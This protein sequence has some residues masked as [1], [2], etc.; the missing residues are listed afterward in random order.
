MKC[1]TCLAKTAGEDDLIHSVSQHMSRLD[2]QRQTSEVMSYHRRTGTLAVHRRAHQTLAQY[3]QVYGALTL[4]T[5]VLQLAHWVTWMLRLRDPTLDSSTAELYAG[6]VSDWHQVAKEVT[7][8]AL[9]NPCQTPLIRQL[10]RAAQR[11]YKRAPKNKKEP[12]TAG[13]LVRV[14]HEGFDKATVGGRH[15]HLLFCFLCFGPL[16]PGVTV[17]LVAI[18]TL[19]PDPLCPLGLRVQFSASSDVWIA[20]NRVVIRVDED[21]NVDASKRRLVYIPA[22]VFGVD[23]PGELEMYLKVCSPPSGRTLFASPTNPRKVIRPHEVGRFNDGTYT[24][25]CAMVRRAFAR[26]FPDS[27]E[28]ERALLGG[29]SP[30]KTLAILLYSVYANMRLVADFGGWSAQGKLA[31]DCYIPMTPQQRCRKLQSLLTD[32]VANNELTLEQ[33]NICTR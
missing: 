33:A 29:G 21:K 32:L 26:A 12:L 14:L 1:D 18:Y 16:R 24:A 22:G 17:A 28:W 31:I 3:G 27:E 2:L 6:V 15:D 10:L 5:S 11:G 30:R 9:Q 19:V 8:V 23:L 7:G 4:P 20:E 25:T 13:Q